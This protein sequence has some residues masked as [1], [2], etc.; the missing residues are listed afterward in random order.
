MLYAFV[1]PFARLAICIYFRKVFFS[2]ADRIPKKQPVILACNHPTAFLEP[3]ILACFLDRPLYFLVRGDFFKKKVY[4]FFLRALNMLPVYRQKD[5]DYQA[6]K[7]NYST[8]EACNEALKANKTLVIFPEGHA[9]LE[10]RL[11]SL[12]KGLARVAFGFFDK[13]PEAESLQI[14]PVGVNYSRAD[15]Y[16]SIAMIDFGHPIEAKEFWTADKDKRAI[17][18]NKLLEEL[19][20]EMRKQMI[21]VEDPSQDIVANALLILGRSD[22][23]ENNAKIFVRS[24]EPLRKDQA[25]VKQVAK[26]QLSERVMLEKDVETYNIKLLKHGLKDKTLFQPLNNFFFKQLQLILLSLPAVIGYGLNYFPMKQ[27]KKLVDSRIKRIAY[28]P[29]VFISV[30]LGVYFTLTIFFLL[31]SLTISWWL[32]WLILLFLGGGYAYLKYVVLKEKVIQERNRR[33]LTQNQ[34]DELLKE[35]AGIFAKLLV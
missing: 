23:K 35:R 1:R 26:L 22:Q 10:Y 13:Y 33:K 11:R 7:K 9:V 34:Q 27:V 5:G 18:M 24:E 21:I 6:L 4:S 30:S 16:G 25:L 15:Q 17:G 19:A 32:L 12:H 20:K 31:L 14:V 8:F 3:C 2:N 28:Y 29:P